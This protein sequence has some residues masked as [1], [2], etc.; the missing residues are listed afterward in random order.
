MVHLTRLTTAQSR[1]VTMVCPPTDNC[2]QIPGELFLCLANKNADMR[3]A[4]WES[5]LGQ[6]LRLFGGA[7]GAAMTA[8][9]VAALAESLDEQGMPRGAEIH[10]SGEAS[11]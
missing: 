8:A 10:S 7:R 3:A 2:A 5:A 4:A 1:L 11:A 9:D 6:A